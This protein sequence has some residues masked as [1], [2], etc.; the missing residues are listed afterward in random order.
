M[1]QFLNHFIIYRLYFSAKKTK[2]Q[3]II[4]YV[5][6]RKQYYREFT[7]SAAYDLV[8]FKWVA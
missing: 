8:M 3:D 2:K 5:K 1:S 7:D 4:K 6:N